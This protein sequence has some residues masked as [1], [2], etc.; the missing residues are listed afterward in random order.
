MFHFVPS[1]K[2]HGSKLLELNA[3]NYGPHFHEIINNYFLLI[4]K[5]KQ[6]EDTECYVF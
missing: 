2:C 1:I 5:A 4:N 6:K 3:L